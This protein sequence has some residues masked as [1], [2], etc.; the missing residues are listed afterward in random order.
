MVKQI[1]N[2]L[3]AFAILASAQPVMAQQA[4]D[5]PLV[6]FLQKGFF[7][8]ASPN[9]VAFRQGLRDLVH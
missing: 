1:A 5:M 6:G 7:K 4:K 9:I 8:E 2:F 3:T